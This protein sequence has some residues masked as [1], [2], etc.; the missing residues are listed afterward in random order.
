MTVQRSRADRSARRARRSLRMPRSCLGRGTARSRGPRRRRARCGSRSSRAGI[1]RYRAGRRDGSRTRARAPGS[2]VRRRR[3]RARRTRATRCRRSRS[4]ARRDAA[5]NSV[6][7]N[8]RSGFGS[9]ISMNPPRGQMC[10]ALGSSAKLAVARRERELLVAV[11]E[12]LLVGGD[13]AVRGERAPHLG[14]RAVGGEH[15]VGSEPPSAA[16]R[17]DERRSVALDADALLAEAVVNAVAL[18]SELVEQRV[19]RRARY[20]VDLLGRL[21]GRR[22]GTA[23]RRQGRAP[24]GRASGSAASRRPLRCRRAAVL[25]CRARRARD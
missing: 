23:A 15:D 5:R 2:E 11:I 21:V 7:V 9:A 19:Q 18:R 10:S 20:G 13:G 12:Q 8:V 16:V 17:F 22:A 25:R 1:A 24:C 6:A 4:W 14:P 3:T